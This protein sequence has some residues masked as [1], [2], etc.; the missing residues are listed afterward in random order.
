ML[1][2]FVANFVLISIILFSLKK[3]TL[4]LIPLFLASILRPEFLIILILFGIFLKAFKPTFFLSLPL[5][6]F[7]IILN[8]CIDQ[9]NFWWWSTIMYYQQIKKEN[10]ENT[11]TDIIRR[12]E[13][14]NS[15]CYKKILLEETKTNYKKILPFAIKNFILNPIKLLFFP[16]EKYKGKLFILFAFI[17]LAYAILLIISITR[18]RNEK[19]I[20]FSL[21][22]LVLLYNFYFILDNTTWVSRYKLLIIPFEVYLIA[23]TSSGK[24]ML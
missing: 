22:I 21:L 15:E 17:T 8:K 1:D 3:N 14:L 23:K 18:Q 5:I 7:Q 19:L 6:A 20:L 24:S 12:C 10:R 11:Y 2:P 13:K 9:S 16:I 4:S